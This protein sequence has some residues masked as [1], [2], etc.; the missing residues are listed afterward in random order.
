MGM[1]SRRWSAVM[2]S[3]GTQHTTHRSIDSE[4][5]RVSEKQTKRTHTAAAAEVSSSCSTQN[6]A[7]QQP[8]AAGQVE[9]IT[10]SR[11]FLGVQWMQWPGETHGTAHSGGCVWLGSA[12]QAG[13]RPHRTTQ[14]G[15]QAVDWRQSPDSPEADTAESV[16]HRAQ[17][18]VWQLWLL[19]LRLSPRLCTAL[20]LTSS[21]VLVG[22]IVRLLRCRRRNL[23]PKCSPSAGCCCR[24]C[25]LCCVRPQTP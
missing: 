14:P 5:K 1:V 25:R 10:A 3:P 7:A 20:V 15:V 23:P 4:A 16:S 18:R 19:L 24:C 22:G 2:V 8:R 21:L 13:S 9:P 12:N 6:R 17:R 11:L